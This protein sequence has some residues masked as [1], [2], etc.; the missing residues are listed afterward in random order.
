[1]YLVMFAPFPEPQ[2]KNIN[3]YIAAL[4]VYIKKGQCHCVFATASTSV[5]TNMHTAKAFMERLGIPTMYMVYSKH[6]E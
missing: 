2:N 5:G 1:M 3:I 6:M 4:V